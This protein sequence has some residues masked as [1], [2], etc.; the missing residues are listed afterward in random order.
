MHGDNGDMVMIM[1]QLSTQQP[2]TPT[3]ACQDL[4]AAAAQSNYHN[5]GQTRIALQ[6]ICLT[7]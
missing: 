1:T 4:W 3:T 7:C 5:I 6:A 2:K